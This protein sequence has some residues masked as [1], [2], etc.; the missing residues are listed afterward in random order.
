MTLGEKIKYLRQVEGTLRGYNRPLSQVEVVRSIGTELGSKIS[1]A[2]LSQVESGARKHLSESTR[3][4]LA[5]FFKVHPGYLVS[6]PE[7][8]HS[9]LMSDIR[10]S[11][12]TLDLWLV[13]GAE[14][15]S[16]D[17]EV[18]KALLAV[19]HNKDSRRC[20][21]L[22]GMI[23]DMPDLAERLFKLLR[24]GDFKQAAGAKR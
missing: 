10:A 6:D 11:E 8:Y 2:Y 3:M 1:Q 18:K 22:L 23:L 7:G 4:L 15:F 13:A 9:E 19:A 21:L 20:L 17:P 12:D 5:T 14:R 24:P 16:S